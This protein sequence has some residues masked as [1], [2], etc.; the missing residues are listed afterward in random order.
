MPVR[1]L[2]GKKRKHRP[3]R[4]ARRR[5]RTGYDRP[6]SARY[7]QVRIQPKRPARPH[8]LLLGG[9]RETAAVAPRDYRRLPKGDDANRG[10]RARCAASYGKIHRAR[11]GVGGGCVPF[12]VGGVPNL[13]G[14]FCARNN[15]RGGNI[16]DSPCRVE[17]RVRPDRRGGS[18][19][20]RSRG[21][22]AGDKGN[23]CDRVRGDGAFVL[24]LRG[25]GKKHKRKPFIHTFHAQLL[26]IRGGV[27]GRLRG[28][29]R[30]VLLVVR[31]KLGRTRR[32]GEIVLALL[33][34]IGFRRAR[35]G[36]R[37]LPATADAPK[38]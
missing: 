17:V 36:L 31:S 33:G 18:A 1:G 10:A 19:C 13:F 26:Q 14:I 30:G 35:I 28:G 7:G 21:A 20:R 6:Q 3:P 29:V 16:P 12:D 34:E 27:R 23:V 4:N 8:A 11:R 24:R 5:G 25:G 22:F 32:R 9:L 2:L 38:V 15:L 37:V